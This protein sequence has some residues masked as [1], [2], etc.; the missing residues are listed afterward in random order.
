MN[1]SALITPYDA[2][3]WKQSRFNML[4]GLHA[5]SLTQLRNAFDA[6]YLRGLS[7]LG[8]Q[9]ADADDTAGTVMEKRI[10]QVCRRPWDVLIG[11]DVPDEQRAQALL[12]QAELK[13]FFSNLR[14]RNAVQLN[15]HGSLRALLRQM[16]G[17]VFYRYAA[18]EIA[19]DFSAGTARATLWH[20]PLAFME[21]TTGELRFAGATGTTPGL[22][23]DSVNWLFAVHHRALIK[24]LSVLYLI[25]KLSLSDWINFCEKFGTPGLHMETTATPGSKEWNDAVTALASFARDWSAVTSQGQKIHL[26]QAA[27][28]AG[29]GPFA[30]LVDLANRAMARV[31]LGSDLATMSRE[32]GAGASLQGEDTD[33]L[34]SADCEWISEVLNEQLSRRVIAWKFGEG[35]EPLA[36]FKLSGPQRQDTEME[37][38]VDDH[39]KK[40][41][42][43][44]SV[45]DVAE[46]YGRTHVERP[47]VTPPPGAANEA[48]S[49]GLRARLKAYVKA[50]FKSDFKPAQEA[51]LRLEQAASAD[52]L[53][54]ALLALDPAAVESSL[55]RG[56][57]LESALQSVIAAEFLAGLDLPDPGDVTAEN[58]NPWRDGKNGRFTTGPGAWSGPPPGAGFSKPLQETT[59]IAEVVRAAMRDA[60]SKEFTDYAEVDASEA[61][62]IKRR[63][64]DDR[65]LTGY[66]RT[67]SADEVRKIME[68]HSKDPR[69]ITLEDFARLK[70]LLKTPVSQHWEAGRGNTETLI[71]IVNDNGRLRIV[72]E[73]RTGRR[74]LSLKSMY[75]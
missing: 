62:E 10:S 20:V 6:G 68:K 58:A 4:A 49:E 54:A 42:V 50:A 23:L 43:V 46:R 48:V 57:A 53:R 72:E 36:F 14:T 38:K 71:S 24:S 41:G 15:D 16:M 32:N 28:G 19:W 35:V 73:Q 8:E 75:R 65:D 69:P 44:L 67:L 40:H 34:I 12:H 22:S 25:K 30:P 63:T 51:L 33:E 64:G 29:E 1:K 66:H 27:A 74:K 5:G 17:A 26:I 7:I 60:D 2:A 47:A 13:S 39:V 70:L 56:E 37:M 55:I 11:E 21:D 52:E 31:V 59:S 61:A 3:R 18:H 9:I 45:D